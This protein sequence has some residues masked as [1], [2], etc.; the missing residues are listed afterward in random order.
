MCF[1]GIGVHSHSGLGCELA[2]TH[3]HNQRH[4]GVQP[5]ERQMDGAGSPGHPTGQ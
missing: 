4:T 1:V 5:R 2:S 3:C